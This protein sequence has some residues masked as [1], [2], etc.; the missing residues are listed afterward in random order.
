M[1]DLD[2]STVALN[3]AVSYLG[4]NGSTAMYNLACAYALKGDREAGIQWLE[5]SVNAGF[6]SP[7]KLRN[8]P[9]INNLRNDAR[10]SAI[11]KLSSTLTL[12]Q[13]PREKDSFNKSE[14]SDYS[15][16]RWAPAISLYQTFVSS[17]PD[18]SQP[19]SASV[20]RLSRERKAIGAFSTL[21]MAATNPPPHNIVRLQC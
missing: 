1:R 12:S 6:D 10:F 7:E 21:G 8:D 17:N 2:R 14:N 19:G 9:D 16:Q 15:K 13:F 18:S 20:M 11:E 4:D 5:K 3:R